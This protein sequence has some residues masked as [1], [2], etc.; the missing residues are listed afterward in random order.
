[1]SLSCRP[2]ALVLAVLLALAPRLASAQPA[3]TIT[4]GSGV[5]TASQG[6]DLVILIEG[7]DRG[8][9]GGQVLLDGDDITGLVLALFRFEP[10]TTGTSIRSPHIPMGFLGLGTHTFRVTLNLSDGS[11]VSGGASWQVLR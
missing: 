2:L 1:M 11:Q 5:F 7:L 8:I 10:L 6:M 3:V 4:P 9:A